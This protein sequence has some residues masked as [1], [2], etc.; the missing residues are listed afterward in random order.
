MVFNMNFDGSCGPVNPGG[1]AGYGFVITY[2][3]NTVTDS[4]VIGSGP[5][6]S[7]N[8]AEFYA[9]AKGL[10]K[11]SEIIATNKVSDASI[12]VY[13]DSKLVINIMAGK[14]KATSD[15]LYYPALFVASLAHADIKM[16]NFD[17][18]YIWIEREKNTIADK[19]SKVNHS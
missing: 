13:G 17:I 5:Q 7:N 15:K 2:D 19:L 4:A 11:I 10:E 12:R 18:K 16:K 8:Y 14:W 9:L 6:Y 3:G 1:T